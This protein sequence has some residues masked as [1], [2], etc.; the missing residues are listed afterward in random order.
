MHFIPPLIVGL[1]AFIVAGCAVQRESV[2]AFAHDIAAARVAY[3]EL[4]L[5]AR[6]DAR[7]WAQEPAYS[8]DAAARSTQLRGLESAIE[9][10]LAALRVV[11]AYAELLAALAQGGE[12]ADAGALSAALNA[13]Q[14]SVLARVAERA[15][16]HANAVAQ[17]LALIDDLLR[18]RQ[19]RG[20]VER[21][22]PVIHQLINLMK[23]DVDDLHGLLADHGEFQRHRLRQ[24]A[25]EVSRLIH[26]AAAETKMRTTLAGS[27][28]EALR[29][30]LDLALTSMGMS[31]SP[32]SV[33]PAPL[34]SKRSGTKA[35]A[36]ASRGGAAALVTLDAAVGR[37]EA[38][39]EAHARWIARVAAHRA[40]V[41]ACVALLDQADGA[42]FA[43]AQNLNRPSPDAAMDLAARVLSLRQAMVELRRH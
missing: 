26:A 13:L 21:G 28:G 1:F 41:D 2:S 18:R 32:W 40:A 7:Q 34:S 29:D 31:R 4:L 43:L 3:E 9:T 30:R 5:E 38:I 22:G 25:G 16:P 36:P 11:T 20:V 6:A 39:A 42:M 14:H 37:V 17:G 33:D 19:F 8:A 24:R 23:S 10:R 27:R 12:P 35:T 15:V